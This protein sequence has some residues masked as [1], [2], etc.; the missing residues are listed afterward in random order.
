VDRSQAEGS[1]GGSST[2]LG[3]RSVAV[4]DPGSSE[5]W[6][7]PPPERDGQ[8]VGHSASVVTSTAA[9][10]GGATQNSDTAAATL[11]GS[12]APESPALRAGM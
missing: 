8:Q 11:T 12:R 2:S 6:Y 1:S 9:V 4:P 5:S 10:L 3:I 7:S